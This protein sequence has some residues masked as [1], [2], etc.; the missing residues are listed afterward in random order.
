MSLLLYIHGFL[1][2]PFSGKAQQVENWLKHNEPGIDYVCPALTPYPKEAVTC[3]EDIVERHLPQPVYLLGSSMGGYYAT[4]LAE[5]YNLRA[6]L[7]NPA[8]APYHLI[9]DYL[10]K[11][12]QNYHTEEHYR[13]TREH[14]DHLRALETDRLQYPANFWLMVQTG[15][16]TLDYRQ[17]VE[18][19][20]GCRQWV[21]EGGDHSFQNFQDRLPAIFQFFTDG[22]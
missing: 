19:Y 8:I 1:S 16:E 20:R 17:A 7:I 18:K 21:E 15:D 13:L 14:L 5:K 9:D 10:D 11:D 3:L 2:S 22:V 12:L 4:Y 6:V